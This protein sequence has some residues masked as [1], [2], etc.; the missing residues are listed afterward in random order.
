[1]RRLPSL[2]VTLA[3]L[4]G[5]AAPANQPPLAAAR[6]P[7]KDAG[8]LSERGDAFSEVGD[9][10]RAEQYYGAAIAAGANPAVILPRLLR[11]CLGAGDLRL[12]ADYAETELSRA[13]DN[14]RLRFLVGALHAKVGDGVSARTHLVR[15]ATELP[16]DAEVQFS[17]AAFFRDDM[18]D[19]VA[20]DPFF[21]E[22]LKLEPAGRHAVEA[23][24]SLMETVQ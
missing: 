6:A 16:R 20:S 17:V 9:F 23:K 11:A 21:R 13:P 7:L 4:A 18:K 5:C 24:N 3:L 22:Y 8:L 12:A 19:R 14:A 10:T 1:M 15:A 2:A